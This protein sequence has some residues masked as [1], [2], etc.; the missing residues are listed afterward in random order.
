[1]CPLLDIQRYALIPAKKKIV[2][3]D[4]EKR[5]EIYKQWPL[6]GHVISP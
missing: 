4:Y 3:F 2:S 5:L 1:M 6:I